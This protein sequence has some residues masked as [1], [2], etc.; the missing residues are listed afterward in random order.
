MLISLREELEIA[1]LSSLEGEGDFPFTK[2]ESQNMTCKTCNSQIPEGSKYCNACGAKVVTKR[3]TIKEIFIHISQNIFGWDNSFLRTLT[4][5]TF[6]PNVILQEYLDG[7]RK[8]YVNPV[9]FLAFCTSI[10]LILFNAFSSYYLKLSSFD[11]TAQVKVEA[12]DILSTFGIKDTLA[13]AEQA[14]KLEELQDEKIKPKRAPDPIEEFFM[15]YYLVFSFLML[16]S[17][18]LVSRLV[19]GR[20]H[21]FAE[22][23]AMNAY[24]QGFLVSITLFLFALSLL[25]KENTFFYCSLVATFFYYPFAFGKLYNH[26]FWKAILFLLKFVALIGGSACTIY[27]IGFL[28]GMSN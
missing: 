7:V 20:R 16:P 19:Y 3:I 27:A 21:N 28:A 26:S 12:N 1:K 18:A 13:V 25:T 22:H 6:R 5:L 4:T 15:K 8:K 9:S 24:I 14:D 17:Y 23:L 10:S 2:I 11:T